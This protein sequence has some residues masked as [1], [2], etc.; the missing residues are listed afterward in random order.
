MDMKDDLKVHHKQM[1]NVIQKGY[2]NRHNE[3]DLKYS[4]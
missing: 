4:E 3:D 2:E 1:E